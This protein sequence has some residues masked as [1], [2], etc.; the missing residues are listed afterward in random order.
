MQITIITPSYNAE[1]SIEKTILSVL[2]QKDSNLQYIII[3]GGSTDKTLEIISKYKNKIDIIISEKDK[4]I[5]D[6][7]NKGI[8]LATGDL[9]GI[10]AADDQLINYALNKL[11][12]NYDGHSDVVCGNMIEYN[13][14][15]Y[16]R[17]YSDPVI[18]NLTTRTSLIHP[19]TFIKKEAYLKYGKYSINYKCAI[20]RELF[21]RFYKKGATFQILDFDISFFTCGGISTANPIKYAYKEDAQ[22]SIKYGT[23]I[24]KAKLYLYKAV[25]QYYAFFWVKKFLKVLFLD[26]YF[27]KIMVRKGYYLSDNQIKKL[28][29]L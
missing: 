1:K 5:A 19:A 7:Y 6:S 3:D 23:P 13:G 26:H 14:N 21:L 24:F 16:I 9:I 17:R 10:I 12:I 18:N 15:R 20:D 11:R 27:N 4:G 8:N 22:I 2:R 28:N 29:L 25:L